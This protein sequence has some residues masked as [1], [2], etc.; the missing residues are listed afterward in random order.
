M[1]MQ[2]PKST[3][4]KILCKRNTKFQSG[5]KALTPPWYCKRNHK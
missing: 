3:G 4:L 2:I 5:M 1:A